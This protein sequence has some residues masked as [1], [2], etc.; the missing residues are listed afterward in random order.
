MARLMEQRQTEAEPRVRRC[1][2]SRGA[3]RR[4]QIRGAEAG[5]AANVA[6][7]RADGGRSAS[8]GRDAGA[9]TGD[10]ADGAKERRGGRTV[11]WPRRR[12]ARAKERRGGRTVRGGRDSGWPRAQKSAGDGRDDGWGREGRDG[13]WGCKG[14]DDG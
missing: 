12:L 11:R 6:G 3:H 14:R 10:A 1:R 2:R 7:T 9:E 13:G 5:G 8:Q 4:R